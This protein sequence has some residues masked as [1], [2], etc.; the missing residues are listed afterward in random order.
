VGGDLVPSSG[1]FEVAA[2][3]QQERGEVD[4]GLRV[5]GAGGQ[6]VPGDGVVQAAV[7]LVP[8]AEVVGA[9]E[10]AAR[11]GPLPP[12]P[13]RRAVAALGVEPAEPVRGLHVAGLRRHQQ[14]GLVPHAWRRDG[15]QRPLTF[16]PGHGHRVA[17]NRA[18][19]NRNRR[20][21]QENLMNPVNMPIPQA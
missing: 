11:R 1:L 21:V 18:D 14:L 6:F 5:A 8:D 7:L 19:A 12:V 9:V 20:A 4:R 3:L 15:R 17:C 16:P 10:V 13:G 2:L